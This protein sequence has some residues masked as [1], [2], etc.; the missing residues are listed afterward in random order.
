MIFNRTEKP[1]PKMELEFIPPKIEE[2]KLK[3][4]LKIFFIFKDKLPLIRMNLMINAGSKFDPDD[5]K[6]LAY[7]TSLVLDE[8]VDGL[9][10]L[11]LSDEFD[12]LGTNFNVSAEND[13]INLSLQCLSENFERSFELFSK[14]L[15]H[16]AF[17][18][19]DFLREKKKL[20]TQI[21]QSK[22]EPDYLADQLFDRLVLGDSNKYAFPV[23]GFENSVQSITRA[24][25]QDHFNKFF[26]P[27]NSILVIVGNYL[28]DELLIT[29]EKYTN[30]WKSFNFQ[31][32]LSSKTNSTNRKTFLYHKEG[33]VQT[34]IRVGHT[35]SK[36]NNQD[37]FQKLL[38]NSILGGQ[39]TSRIN[40]NLRERNGYTYGANSR[41]QYF[42]DAGFFQ[43][44]TSVGA[45]NTFDAL[46]EIFFELD[47]IK[48]GITDKELEFAKSSITKKFPINFETYRQIVS[49]VSGKILFELPDDYFETYILKI[50]SISKSEV[51]EMALK[52][53]KNDE[54]TIVLV[55][56]KNILMPKI[57]DLDFDIS[58]VNM[59][60]N[61]I[62]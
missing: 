50:N 11:E 9:N 56:D 22:D 28:K 47:N 33:S 39:F 49:S 55:G 4:G 26:S 53:I 6:G 10:A 25:V 52:S 46:R 7:L 32:I 31:S 36:R 62:N 17:N 18:E 59:N 43:V 12:I 1:I 27:S 16:P 24:D 44:A 15:L 60:G 23:I 21:L 42:K 54:L 35:S 2:I 38:L 40:L 45:E 20:I 51:E 48:K 61:L 57:T 8:G 19:E 41:F 58:E 37:Y 13:L 29:I 3:N 34:E 14:V 30:H 5:K